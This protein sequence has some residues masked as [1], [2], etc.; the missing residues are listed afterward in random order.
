MANATER[1]AEEIK[2]Q[3]VRGMGAMKKA[4]MDLSQKGALSKPNEVWH[5]TNEYANFMNGVLA[6]IK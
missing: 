2:E 4:L 6:E 5:R 3:F 1:S